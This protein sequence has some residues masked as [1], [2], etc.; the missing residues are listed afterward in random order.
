MLD[1]L[2]NRLRPCIPSDPGAPGRRAENSNHYTI[3]VVRI[4]VQIFWPV[5]R[6]LDVPA[7]H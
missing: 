5:Q 7:I 1:I 4:S 3:C 6:H 2:N